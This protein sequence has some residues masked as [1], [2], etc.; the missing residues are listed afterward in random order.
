[1]LKHFI[2]LGL[3]ILGLLLS[4]IG[5]DS[6]SDKSVESSVTKPPLTKD[7]ASTQAETN[8]STRPLN[9]EITPDMIET[10]IDTDKDTSKQVS[11]KPGLF[12]TRPVKKKDKVNT[13]FGVY[14]D[15]NET[16][17]LN[18]EGIEG[19]KIEIEIIH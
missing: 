9:L 2:I 5:C 14:F 8:I 19:G 17:Y 15:E 11:E 4:F 1:M 7:K 12:D 6:E 10:V 3:I 18:P 16:D 13:S